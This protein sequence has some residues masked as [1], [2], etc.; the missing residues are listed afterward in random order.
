MKSASHSL[1]A[2]FILTLFLTGFVVGCDQQSASESEREFAGALVKTPQPVPD[3]TL[4]SADG[5]VSLSDFAGKYVFIYFGYTFCPDVCPTTLSNLAAVRQEL[6]DDADKIQV[7]MVSVDPERDTPEA[8][9]TYT[10]YFDPTFIGLTG[11]KEEI[12][13]VGEPLGVFYSFH[14]GTVASG[15]L[16][17]HTAR[18]F[19]IDPAGNARVAYPHDAPRDGIVADLKW[20]FTQE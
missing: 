18:T 7:I 10:N 13:A 12:D 14:E 4:T 9:D 15:Y 17:D 2:L 1:F 11:A 6:G 16:I 8:L 3:F 19:M 5:P 20:F